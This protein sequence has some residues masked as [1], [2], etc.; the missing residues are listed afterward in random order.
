MNHIKL[1]RFLNDV[2]ALCGEFSPS[3]IKDRAEK[4]YGTGRRQAPSTIR[5]IPISI[6]VKPRVKLILR[7]K[8]KARFVNIFRSLR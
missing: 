1:Q 4:G 3:C 7:A 5:T 8:L 2:H 6:R